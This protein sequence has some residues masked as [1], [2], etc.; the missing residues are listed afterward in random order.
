MFNK[1]GQMV[2]EALVVMGVAS[3]ILAAVVNLFIDIQQ[4]GLLNNQR[5]RANNLV[6]EG[7]EAARSAR[8]DGWNAVKN[9]GTYHPVANPTTNKWELQA[10]GETGIDGLFNRSIVISSVYRIASPASPDF[11]K[12]VSSGTSG[13]KEDKSTKQITVNVSWE[14]PRHQE[15]IQKIYLT[16]FLN[17]T[18][19]TQTTQSDFNGDTLTNTQVVATTPPPTGNGSVTLATGGASS[20][21][22]NQFLL[23]A[24]SGIG[25]LTASTYKCSNRF[26]AQNSKTVT[27]IRVYLNQEN[28]NSPTYRYGIQ[29]DNA[30]LPSGTFLGY[31][32]V[33]ATT[34][35]WRELTLNTPVAITAGQVYHIVVQYQS[36]T[37]A[38]NRYINIQR[39]TPLNLLYPYNNA[40]ESNANTLFYNGSSWAIQ[41]YQ[42]VYLLVFNDSTY[43]GNPYYTSAAQSIFGNNFRGEKF[44]VSGGDK[45]V[46]DISFYIRK[47]SVL[48]PVANLTVNLFDVTGN[49][50][51]EQGTIC[52]PAE[53]STT[54]D[55]KTYT[56]S[57]PRTL[58]N[59]RTYRIYLSSSGSGSARYYQVYTIQNTNSA[60]YN[61]VNYDGT[62][63]VYSYSTNSGTSYTDSS[64]YDI[65]GF[66]FTVPS[67]GYV[68]SGTFTSSLIDTTAESAFN[69]I[70]FDTSLP[71]NTQI[72]IQIAT[73]NNAGGPWNFVGPDG[74]S[75]SYYTTASN[76]EIYLN[77]IL[78]RYFKYQATLSTSNSSVTP[79]LDAV[80]INYSP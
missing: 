63:S 33:A 37:I 65:S 48:N 36:G 34:T 26:T 77:N 79:S 28:G 13:A 68:S 29:A 22:G 10:G 16:R 45:T 1:K 21:Y 73:S 31:G 35:G 50:L 15:I 72:N 55:W 66:R 39:S 54:Y 3:I 30:G 43:E 32:D 74:S 64:D 4:G 2:I 70:S 69:N 80:Y 27:R 5:T 40:T 12:I 71:A 6:Q 61:G 58:Q 44:V 47:N 18:L 7:L 51:I 38:T 78:G 75:S 17:N 20:N 14:T 67:T 46:S 56:F 62:N 42:P 8:Y 49:T 9:N 53:A 24:T 57:T 25:A 19:A 60:E 11:M 41:N 52:T 23:T 76:K 59:G